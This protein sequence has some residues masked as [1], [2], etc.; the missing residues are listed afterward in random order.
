MSI[1]VI[2][3]TLNEAP[4]LGALLGALGRETVGHEVIVVDGGSDDGTAARAR[5][6]GARVLETPPGRGG[7]LVAGAGAARGEVLFFLH[8]DTR[9]PAGGL[10]AIE[11]ALAA[12]P[13]VVGGNFRV[14]FDGDDDFSRWLDGFYAWIR[15]HGFYYGDSGVFVRRRVYDALGGIRPVELMEDYD[16]NRR[17]EG[18]GKTVCIGDPAL[19]SSARRFA[20]RRPVN[21]VTD[22]F[23][24]HG[25]FH[26]GVPPGWLAKFYDSARR[27]RRTGDRPTQDLQAGLE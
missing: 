5:Q 13:G 9:F 12:D 16:F 25:L 23:L 10:A 7:Q 27:R 21:I 1:S 17:M 6:L 8:A 26:L 19:V 22:W 3:P 20:G 24:I 14:L 18:F 2:I 15:S 4:R 11:R